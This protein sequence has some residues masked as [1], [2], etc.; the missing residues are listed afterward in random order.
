MG[1]WAWDATRQRWRKDL[2]LNGRRTKLTVRGTKKDAEAYEAR[3]RIELGA[4]GVVR[5]S[6]APG[7][8]SFCVDRYKPHAK[9]HLRASTWD[10]RRYQLE[11]LIE[12]FGTTRLT[13]ITTS[14]VEAFKVSRDAGKVTVNNELAVLSAVLRYARD[15]LGLP[16]AKPAIKKFAV[17]ERRAKVKAFTR[18]EM[19][20]VLQ[21]AAAMGDDF[22]ALVKFI[23]E[24][25]CRKSEAINLPWDRVDLLGRMARIWSSDDEGDDYEVKSIEREV[26]LPDSLVAVLAAQ[27]KRSTSSWV[28]AV[29]EGPSAGERYV[30]WPKWTWTRALRHASRLAGA[31]ITGGPHRLRHTFASLFLQTKPDLFLLGRILGHSHSRVTELYSHLL[32]DH[33]ATTRGVV[34]F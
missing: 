3:K 29:R 17:R 19:S 8:A 13:K 23:A 32:P 24:T 31:P 25:G 28:F 7:F 34:E 5:T 6:D 22:F 10:V 1:D 11:N 15:T 30:A 2:W 21:G 27:K 12:F 33:L 18:D 16:C 14:Q 4:T 9:A 20:F 26:T